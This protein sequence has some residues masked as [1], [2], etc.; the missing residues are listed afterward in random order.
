MFSQRSWVASSFCAISTLLFLTEDSLAQR[1][2]VYLHNTQCVLKST[3]GD[4]LGSAAF[5]STISEEIPVGRELLTSILKFVVHRESSISMTCKLIKEGEKSK[6]KTLI[7]AF[8]HADRSRRESA[9]IAVY[10]DGKGYKSL[11][12]TPSILTELMIDVK[13]VRNVELEVECSRNEPCN[14]VYFFK[15]N[16]IAEPISPGSR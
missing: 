16:L 5:H 8:A 4:T 15:S 10:L 1:K 13:G 3:T 7:L 14:D 2:P 6:Y 9:K 12:V 11:T